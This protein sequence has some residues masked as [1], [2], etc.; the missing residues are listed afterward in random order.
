[1][2]DTTSVSYAASDE[3]LFSILV[4]VFELANKKFYIT[5]E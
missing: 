5:Q 3:S 4:K 1:V 2:S